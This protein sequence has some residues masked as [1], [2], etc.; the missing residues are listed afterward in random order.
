MVVHIPVALQSL[1]FMVSLTMQIPQ[2]LVDT[3]IDVL[4][5]QCGEF[6]RCRRGE[7]CCAPTA[8]LGEKLVAGSS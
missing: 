8:A 2:L 1:I 4:V 5:V 6:H 3:V 7:V